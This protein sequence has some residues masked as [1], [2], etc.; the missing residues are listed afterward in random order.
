MRSDET[1]LVAAA[2]E[3][4]RGR[5]ARAAGNEGMA[6]TCARRAA[7]RALDVY[8]LHRPGSSGGRSALGRLQALQHEP[9]VPEAVRR[10]AEHLTA[11]VTADHTLPFADD[12]IADAA[13][14][15]R[16]VAELDTQADAEAQP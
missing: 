1:A 9:G 15:V 5:R 4:E 14:I 11:R 8:A 3:L 10:A 2:A 13:V 7:G 6:R 16:F 12:P